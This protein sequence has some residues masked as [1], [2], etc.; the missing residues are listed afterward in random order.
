MMKR[1]DNRII[2]IAAGGNGIRETTHHRCSGCW[3]HE[4][5]VLYV[6]D[7]LRAGSRALSGLRRLP[8]APDPP[9][10]LENGPT[11]GGG[12]ECG[13]HGRQI[14]RR[15]RQVPPEEPLSHD[16]RSHIG[17][18][19]G[20]GPSDGPGPDL[21][22]RSAS[23]GRVAEHPGI[24]FPRHSG[25]ASQRGRGIIRLLH[26]ENRKSQFRFSWCSPIH[27]SVGACREVPRKS[28]Y[29]GTANT[30][31]PAPCQAAMRWLLT[32]LAGDG[33]AWLDSPVIV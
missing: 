4:T 11:C 2:G 13:A 9:P 25:S 17:H 29:G 19:R 16:L 7:S 27:R 30:A 33:V 18:C 15:R 1:G 32:P 3:N 28:H 14:C 22:G 10:I 8:A 31:A 5:E 20:T 6:A 23:K 24:S 21:P 12:P 26:H